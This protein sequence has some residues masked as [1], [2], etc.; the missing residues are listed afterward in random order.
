MKTKDFLVGNKHRKRHILLHK[1]LDELVADFINHTD[2]LPSETPLMAL[3]EW[4]YQQTQE[5]AT[6]NYKGINNG[7]ETKTR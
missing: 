4:S 1:Y 7:L 3:M 2:K 6:K 5:L